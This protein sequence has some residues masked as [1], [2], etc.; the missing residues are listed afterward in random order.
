MDIEKRGELMKAAHILPRSNK[1]SGYF[2]DSVSWEQVN[3]GEGQYPGAGSSIGGQAVDADDGEYEESYLET[4]NIGRDGQATKFIQ[5]V[6]GLSTASPVGNFNFN[7]NGFLGA[8]TLPTSTTWKQAIDTITKTQA[9]LD[10]AYVRYQAGTIASKAFDVWYEAHCKVEFTPGYVQVIRPKADKTTQWQTAGA[11]GGHWDRINSDVIQPTAGDTSNYVFVDENDDGKYDY[12]DFSSIIG[13]KN[14]S[15]IKVW[16]YAK[17][18]NSPGNVVVDVYAGGWLGGKTDHSFTTSYAW[19][20]YEWTGLSKTQSDLDG[21]YL[22]YAVIT[23]NSGEEIYIATAYIEVT[24][25]PTTVAD[26]INNTIGQAPCGFGAT[27]RPQYWKTLRFNGIDKRQV[28][29]NGCHI[30]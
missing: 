11:G 4:L 9:N 22:K 28:S 20:S 21:L 19:Y 6:D 25:E 2:T 30:V 24:Y 14:V 10:A 12:I 23:M 27:C 17:K 7:V 3:N 26:R 15:R 16:L 18:V 1:R 5:D 13:I 8:I 29:L